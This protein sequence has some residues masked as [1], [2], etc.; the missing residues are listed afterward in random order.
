MLSV[1][2]VQ[3]VLVALSPGLANAQTAQADAR[4]HRVEL[5]FLPSVPASGVPPASTTLMERMVEL[6]IPGVSIAVVHNGRIDWA[7]GY[8]VL[9]AGGPPVTTDTLFQAASISKPVTALA[10]LHLAEVGKIDLDHQANEYL[11][12][13]KIPESTFTDKS[14]VTVAEL[15]NHTAGINIGGYP[16]YT[17]GQPLPNLD[18]MLRGEPPALGAPIAV[19]FVPGSEFR[20]AGGGYVVLRALLTDVTGQDFQQLMH[21]SVL[22]PL[23]MSH[24]TFQQPLPPDLAAR[25]TLPHYADGKPFEHGARI[26]PEQS[27]DGLWTTASDIARYILAMQKSLAQGG[28]LS[29][30]TARRMFTPGKEDWGLGP[31]VGTDDPAHPYFIFSGGNFGFISFFVAYENG[32]GVAILTNGEQGGTMATELIH[33]VAKVYGWPDFQRPAVKFA[34]KPSPRSMDALTGVYRDPSGSLIAVVRTKDKLNFVRMGNQIGPIRL[35]AQSKDHFTFSTPSET[36]FPEKEVAVAFTRAP[37]GRARTLSTLLNGTATPI[38]AT[39]LSLAEEQSKLAQLDAVTARFEK[40]IPIPGSADA[41]RQL[42]AN[43]DAGTPENLHLGS[44]IAEVLRVDR[45]GNVKIFGSLGAITSITYMSTS[46]GG[47]DTYR[48]S[49]KNGVCVFHILFDGHAVIQ[50]LNVRIN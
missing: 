8:G 29:K 48:V 49:F 30:E 34:V 44:S 18:A 40:Q 24:S 12:R 33:T 2:V 35:F 42:M 38:V 7:K 36:R 43:V 46:P 13:W 15:L 6:H 1:L 39:R 10:V 27:P 4:M 11:R 45:V 21:D 19:T 5:E 16:G 14:K 3:G 28:F 20:Y 50:D 22:V 9:W 31:I 26:Y 41:L 37:D 17:P 47:W 25:A 23:G 32:D